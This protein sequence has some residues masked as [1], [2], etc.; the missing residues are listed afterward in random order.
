MLSRLRLENIKIG[1]HET[2]TAKFQFIVNNMELLSLIDV[3][4]Y[5][6]GSRHTFDFVYDL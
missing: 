1:K 5:S 3:T 2:Q 6:L 4:F